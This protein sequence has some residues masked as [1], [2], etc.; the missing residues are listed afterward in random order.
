[1]I[2]VF[3]YF[4]FPSLFPFSSLYFLFAFVIT[5][6]IRYSVAFDINVVQ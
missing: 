6:I 3:F 5:V 2:K 4:F 1:M